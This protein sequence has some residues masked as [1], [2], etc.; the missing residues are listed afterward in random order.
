[1]GPGIEGKGGRFSGGTD[2]AA[3]AR[4]AQKRVTGAEDDEYVTYERGRTG[5]TVRGPASQKV[6]G[7]QGTFKGEG[8]DA[9]TQRPKRRFAGSKAK[10]KTNMKLVQA[11]AT[12]R[13]NGGRKGLFL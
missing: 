12:K 8:G 9:E 5:G 4:A 3:I 1:M 2:K 13:L 11:A 6:S 10:G 7:T